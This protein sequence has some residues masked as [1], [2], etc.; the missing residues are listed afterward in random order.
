[1]TETHYLALYRKYRPQTFEEV[2]GR[3][4]IVR[5]LRNQIM[6]G[7][8]GH[9]YLF[10]GTRGTGKTTIA[11]IFARA[12]N[13]EHPVNG[14]PCGE[15]AS[16]RAIAQD[17]NLNVVEMDAASNNGVDDIRNIIEQVEYSPSQGRYRIYIIDEAHMLSKGAQNSLLKTLE[18]PPS[19]AIFILATTEPEKLLPTIISRCQRFDFGRLSVDTIKGM[20]AEVCKRENITAEDRALSYIAAAADGSMRD[21]LSI[22]DECNAFIPGGET[23]TYDKTLEILGALDMKVFSDLF[24]MI[25]EGKALESVQKLDEI[26]AQGREVSQFI[27]DFLGYLR[28]CMLVKASESAALELDISEDARR[29]V[30]EDAR[31][32]QMPEIIRYINVLSETAEQIRFAPGRKTLMETALIRL[33]EPSMDWGKNTEQKLDSLQNRILQ[34]ENIVAMMQQKM[35]AGFSGMGFNAQAAGGM[36][37][38]A[39]GMGTALS[40]TAG[41]QPVMTGSGAGNAAA[42]GSVENA[43]GSEGQILAEQLPQSVPEDIVK[44]AKEWD[45]LIGAI[46]PD[47]NFLKA[48]LMNAR[49]SLSQEGSLM[50][51]LSDPIQYELFRNKSFDFGNKFSAYLS[52]HYGKKI[53]VTYQLDN[54]D[55]ATDN[56]LDIRKLDFSRL[57][58]TV[59]ED[60]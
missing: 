25:H 24:R 44:I 27:T 53:S 30:T 49:P 20:L 11:K 21:G 46:P 39:G 35:A 51:V 12:V 22:L 5:T 4:P 7:H 1:M 54:D 32:A 57:H 59:E 38:G 18:E 48:P 16:C 56:K 14:S 47:K 13:C 55:K 29:L 60:E 15:C 6:T 40:G 50:V 8:I 43:S 58:V 3:D 17:A 45:S 42:D 10:C 26:L 34:L 2:R 31:M 9:S 41:G 23:L 37:Q 28:N 36:A 33:C 52:E 19:Y